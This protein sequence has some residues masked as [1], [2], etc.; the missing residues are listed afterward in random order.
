MSQKPQETLRQ[1]SEIF[2]SF[3]EQWKDDQVPLGDTLADG[4][5]YE[6]THHNVMREFL[7]YFA[8][9]HESFTAKQLRRIGAWINDADSVQGDLEN[10]VATCFLEHAR[11]VKINRVLGPYLSLEAKRKLRA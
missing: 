10:A 1:L 11:Q 7:E 4:V 9:N 3:G 5:Y 6:W 8:S 2:P